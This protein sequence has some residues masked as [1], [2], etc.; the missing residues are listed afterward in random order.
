MKKILVFLFLISF[1]LISQVFSN[2][3][4]VDSQLKIANIKEGSVLYAGQDINLLI[5]MSSVAARSANRLTVTI[6]L[7]GK[8]VASKDIFGPSANNPLMLQMPDN[9]PAGKGTIKAVIYPENNFTASSSEK[10]IIIEKINP[11]L[12]ITNIQD[13]E[14][15]YPGQDINANITVTKEAAVSGDKLEIG[16]YKNDTL[17]TSKDT[18]KL[19]TNNSIILHIPDN[20]PLSNSDLRVNLSP[21]DKFTQPKTNKIIKIDRIDSQ[22][23]IPSIKNDS[24]FHKGQNINLIIEISPEALKAANQIQIIAKDGGKIFMT[25]TID[26]P[27]TRNQFYFTVPLDLTNSTVT[28]FASLTPYNAFNLSSTYKTIHVNNMNPKLN[29]AD[30]AKIF[31]DEELLVTVD[32]D[33]DAARIADKLNVSIYHD[34]ELISSK[35]IEDPQQTNKVNL[36]IIET[37]K[38]KNY[39]IYA[40]LFPQTAFL[41]YSTYKIVKVIE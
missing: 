28:L 32:M 27:Q 18:D 41:P 5:Q 9:T 29:I 1:I 8:I 7:D 34:D 39:T 12:N 16:V 31:M 26:K 6:N 36:K 19:Q 35:D 33:P 17:V 2:L 14:K 21:E 22:L 40:T 15:F 3:D 38:T 23:D 30:T 24:F 13:N 11:K 10:E 20:A 4:T 37:M 25:K